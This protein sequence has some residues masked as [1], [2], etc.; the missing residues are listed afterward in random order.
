MNLELEYKKPFF[1]VNGKQMFDFSRNFSVEELF[2]TSQGDL[3]QMQNLRGVTFQVFRN[4]T[5]LTLVLESI[6]KFLGDVPLRISSGYRCP[7]L[8]KAVG[9]VPTSNHL[10]GCAA[11]LYVQSADHFTKYLNQLKSLGIL[12]EVIDYGSFYHIAIPYYEN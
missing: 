8:N 12:S 7:A 3:L 2:A 1:T 10:L 5:R 4:L 6:R 11:D 9:G